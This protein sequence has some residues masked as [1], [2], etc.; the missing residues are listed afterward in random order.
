MIKSIASFVTGQVVSTSVFKNQL[1]GGFNAVFKAPKDKR[2]AFIFLGLE[3]DENPIEPTTI[4]NQMGWYQK[5]IK[6]KKKKKS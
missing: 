1:G 2:F 6:T 3:D 5:E 4:L